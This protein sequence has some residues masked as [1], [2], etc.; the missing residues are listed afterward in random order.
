MISPTKRS[1]FVAKYQLKWEKKHRDI[2][3]SNIVDAGIRAIWLIGYKDWG[4]N[5]TRKWCGRKFTLKHPYALSRLLKELFPSGY[6][7]RRNKANVGKLIGTLKYKME[8]DE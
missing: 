4:L 6:F 3:E 5:Q 1:L 7:V 8:N 2:L